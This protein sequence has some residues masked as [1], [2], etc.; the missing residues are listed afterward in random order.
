MFL[1]VLP[2]MTSF[3]TNITNFFSGGGPPDP[4]S[5]TVLSDPIIYTLIKTKFQFTQ[6]E[7]LYTIP[8]TVSLQK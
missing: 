7:I 6:Y 3:R 5:S 4:P 1:L 8:C 2:K